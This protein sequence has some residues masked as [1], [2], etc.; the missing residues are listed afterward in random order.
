MQWP[1]QTTIGVVTWAYV[2]CMGEHCLLLK[3][4]KTIGSC[5]ADTDYEH[6]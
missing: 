2:L 4:N 6:R 3:Y 1:E 5:L